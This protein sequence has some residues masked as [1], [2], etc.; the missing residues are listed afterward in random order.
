MSNSAVTD[1]KC[2][3]PPLGLELQLMAEA[4]ASLRGRI[5]ILGDRL[6]PVMRPAQAD[7]ALGR[8][9][10]VPN[11]NITSPVVES[12]QAMRGTLRE[13]TSRISDILALLEV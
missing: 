13:E 9:G 1:A 3:P 11:Q 6:T 7:K 10:D 4:L 2:E 8:G 12:L 5:D